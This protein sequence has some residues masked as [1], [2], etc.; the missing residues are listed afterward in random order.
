MPRD[1][2]L[3]A[4]DL[5]HPVPELSLDPY[6]SRACVPSPI[7]GLVERSCLLAGH[8]GDLLGRT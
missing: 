1:V 6:T 4:T 8:G 2:D 7:R 3:D 5:G